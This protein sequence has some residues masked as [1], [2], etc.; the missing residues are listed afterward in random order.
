MY[1]SSCL[2]V[3]VLAYFLN[4]ITI[5][6]GYHRALAHDA[7]TLHPFLRRLVLGLGPLITGL[8]PKAWVVMHRM[9]HAHSDSKDDPHSPNNA[10]ILGIM[11]E[12]LR[13]YKRIALGLIKK[14][15]KICKY[16]KS[17]DYDLHSLTRKNLWYLP[18]LIHGFTALLPGIF[19]GFWLLG[20]CYFVGIMSHPIQG[21]LVNAFGHAVGSRN[22]EI[23]DDS[24]NNWL[25]AFFVLGEGLQNNHH[26]F[27][28]SAKFS[29]RSWEPDPGFALCIVLESMGLM[30]ID[31]KN[32]IPVPPQFVQLN[33][34]EVLDFNELRHPLT[35]Q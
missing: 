23:D 20:I 17:L 5:S 8:D 1:L 16:A 12:Q 9:H 30:T 19:G 22:F 14:D 15:P 32:L 10:G 33:N 2:F 3:L 34:N 21:G 4:I 28:Q 31:N 25:V 26:R 11:S 29:Y 7:I 13:S 18:Y 24:R 35:V 6:V 27:P